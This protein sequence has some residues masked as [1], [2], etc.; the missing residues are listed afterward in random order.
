MIVFQDIMARLNEKGWT[1]YKLRKGSILPEGTLTRLRH[2]Q[3]ITTETIDTLCRLCDC[4]PGD[5][6]RYEPDEKEGV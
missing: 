5:L 3:P 4:Q 1:S 2:G 6:M